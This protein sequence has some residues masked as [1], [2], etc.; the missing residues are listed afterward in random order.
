M[1]DNRPI[2][3]FDSGV[4]GLTVLRALQH[5][6][7]GESTLYLGDLARCPY[8]P[9][10]QSE[11]REFALQIADRLARADIKALV[12]ACNTATAAAF[13][14]VRD[15]YPFPV[16][17]VIE[18]SAREAAHR[19]RNGKIGVIA[20]DGTVASGAYIQAIT[21]LLPG[22]EVFQ[23]SASWLVPL[24]ER[25]TLG[26]TSIALQLEPALAALRAAGIDT[27]VLGCTHFPIVR[28]IFEDEIGPG[29]EI[30]DSAETT[31]RDVADVLGACDLLGASEPMH[32]IVVT[33]PAEA[34]A[35][36]AQ[37]MFRASIEIET[38]DLVADYAN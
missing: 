6:L 23:A 19:S 9:R 32:R 33:G 29:I 31:A 14:D 5:R 12:V 21:R 13:A 3:V 4:G 10:P 28:D 2:G 26:R 20:T 17:G 7:P 34:F 22:A 18:P 11:V 37:A 36:R 24:V 27:L 8:G 35:E 30:V 15:R 1:A 25:G 38:V 16:I